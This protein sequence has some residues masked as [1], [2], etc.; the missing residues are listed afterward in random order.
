MPDHYLGARHPTFISGPGGAP[1]A[2]RD[3]LEGVPRLRQDRTQPQFLADLL[4]LPSL[5][6]IRSRP[7]EGARQLTESFLQN[8]AG[9]AAAKALGPI[10]KVAAPLF[11]S[12][13]SLGP[14]AAGIFGPLTKEPV[15][16]A[17]FKKLMSQG[18]VAQ[19]FE[20]TFNILEKAKGKISKHSIIGDKNLDQVGIDIARA[21]DE[22][23]LAAKSVDS[24]LKAA[25]TTIRGKTYPS[26][27]LQA[28]AAQR[29]EANLPPM[30]SLDAELKQFDKISEAIR[31]L[32]AGGEVTPAMREKV[33]SRFRALA[34]STQRTLVEQ[35]KAKT[36]RELAEDFVGTKTKKASRP[37]TKS[38]KSKSPKKSTKQDLDQQATH[39][40]NILDK[41]GVDVKEVGKLSRKKQTEIMNDILKRGK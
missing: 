26:R 24:G 29:L 25:R 16:R 11:K 36:R 5:S 15:L 7:E 39:F 8:A 17:G 4:D 32:S 38:K 35:S 6:D 3:P 37:V 18:K 34:P 33:F 13:Q 31:K 14:L 2:L 20:N 23:R 1:P 9:G 27:K 21:V 19:N 28:L 40:K 41:H 12:F 30:A 10:G 22:A